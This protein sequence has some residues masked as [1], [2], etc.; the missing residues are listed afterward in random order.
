MW[1]VGRPEWESRRA[2]RL[3][4]LVASESICRIFNLYDLYQRFSSAIR[5][6]VD[7]LTP[8]I[9]ANFRNDCPGSSALKFFQRLRGSSR[10]VFSSDSSSLT[11]W[12][13]RWT[14]LKQYILPQR[15]KRLISGIQRTELFP[16]LNAQC[17]GLR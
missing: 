10:C 6:I 5:R 13:F 1:A 16:L 17:E 2:T 7:S 11:Y 14:V 9:D 8:T 12:N 15:H 4:I 3:L